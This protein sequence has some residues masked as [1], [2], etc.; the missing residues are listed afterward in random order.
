MQNRAVLNS[1]E[2]PNDFTNPIA[3]ENQIQVKNM[4]RQR[5]QREDYPSGKMGKQKNYYSKLKLFK[6]DG[7]MT[8]EN[9]KVPLFTRYMEKRKESKGIKVLER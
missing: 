2:S 1:D 6:E 5:P 9:N 7:M 8:N 3:S 4:K